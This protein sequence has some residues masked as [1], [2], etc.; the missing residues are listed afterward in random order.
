[1]RRRAAR[2]WRRRALRRSRLRGR[3]GAGLEVGLELA[4][5]VRALHSDGVVGHGLHETMT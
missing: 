2:A 1:M 3:T 5:V 4:Q